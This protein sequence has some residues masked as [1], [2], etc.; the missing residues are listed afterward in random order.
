LYTHTHILIE[1]QY[2]LISQQFKLK[3]PKVKAPAPPKVK[4]GASKPNLL[5][6]I[7]TPE[8]KLLMLA[9]ARN[10]DAK[11]RKINQSPS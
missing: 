5:K 8:E 1:R 3:S 6:P 2:Q 4:S 11:T 10:L 7:P 9:K